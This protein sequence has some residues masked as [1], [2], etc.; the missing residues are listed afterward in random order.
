TP[1]SHWPSTDVLWNTLCERRAAKKQQRT[2][3]RAAAAVLIIAMAGYIYFDRSMQHHTLSESSNTLSP[4]EQHAVD[5]IA[6]YCAE[7]NISC[8]T[9]DMLELRHDL[10]QSFQKL[11]E[12]DLQLRMYGNDPELIRAKNRIES[13]QARLIKTIVQTL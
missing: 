7:R 9:P 10:E 6:R 13:H 12:I 1:L 8:H 11:N 2:V 4:Q 3:W 5:F